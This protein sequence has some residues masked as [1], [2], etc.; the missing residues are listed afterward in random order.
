MEISNI[1]AHKIISDDII[2]I[3]KFDKITLIYNYEIQ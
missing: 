2:L 1:C 3:F